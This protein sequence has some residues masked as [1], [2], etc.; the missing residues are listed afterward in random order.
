MYKIC[1]SERASHRQRELEQGLLQLM[2]KKHYDDISVCDLCQYMSIP[3]KSFYRY[4][5]G[6]DGALYALLDHTLAEFFSIPST[7]PLTSGGTALGDLDLFFQFWYQQK[8]LL[9]AISYS[10][11]SGIL[12]ERAHAFALREGHIPRQVK[13]WDE[14]IQG[15]AM[16]FSISGLMAM[17]LQWH[18][19]GFQLSAE[20]MIR[21]AASILTR[22]LIQ[23]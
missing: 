2:L 9:D 3:R 16:A 15:I 22:P 6:K 7:N 17:I 1:Q 5:S 13:N 11:L 4:F 19:Q 21:I 20:K 12:I 10:S 18:S 23:P 8:P 14:D